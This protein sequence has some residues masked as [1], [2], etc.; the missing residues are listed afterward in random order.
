MTPS[1]TQKPMS[2]SRAIVESFPRTSQ[3]SS[4]SV[5]T[6][7]RL[8]FRRNNNSLFLFFRFFEWLSFFPSGFLR[9]KNESRPSHG[10]RQR[11]TSGGQAKPMVPF[12]YTKP[13]EKPQQT[14]GKNNLVGSDWTFSGKWLD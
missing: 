8:P 13:N 3:K 7:D 2:R 4:F 5:T 1:I 9:P 11:K 10:K 12:C 14:L 6:F